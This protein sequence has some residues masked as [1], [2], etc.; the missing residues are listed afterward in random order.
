MSGFGPDYDGAFKYICRAEQK[1]NGRF[2]KITAKIDLLHSIAYALIDIDLNLY[3]IKDK[4]STE[5]VSSSQTEDS[6]QK[7]ARGLAKFVQHFTGKD[8]EK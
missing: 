4:L 2:Q 6:A 3:E 1:I 8:S 7:T 5:N